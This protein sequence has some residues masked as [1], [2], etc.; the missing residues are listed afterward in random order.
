M[1]SPHFTDVKTQ[2]MKRLS[3]CQTELEQD[4]ISFPPSLPWNCST[5]PQ[6]V[7]TTN[8]ISRIINLECVCL[9]GSQA[10]INK[11]LCIF[12]LSEI[13]FYLESIFHSRHESAAG[14]SLSGHHSEGRVRPSAPFPW[15]PLCSGQ[16]VLGSMLQSSTKNRNAGFA[17]FI[18]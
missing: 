13:Q 8:T 3:R 1:V 18:P 6:S 17:C 10:A 12:L 16:R 14:W 9:K 7:I 11:C 2:T 4:F 5:F 15:S